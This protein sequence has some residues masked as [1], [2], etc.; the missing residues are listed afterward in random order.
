MGSSGAGGSE[1]GKR[2]NSESR[3]RGKGGMP[4]GH[5]NTKPVVPGG[6]KEED[7]TTEFTEGHGKNIRLY[8]TM[9]IQEMDR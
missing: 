7:L 3:E 8:I 5:Q 2:V 6:R 9:D 1:K 4:R